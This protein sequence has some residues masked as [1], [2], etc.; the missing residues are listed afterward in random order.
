MTRKNQQTYNRINIKN[1]KIKDCSFNLLEFT[2]SGCAMQAIRL[3]KAKKRKC[4]NVFAK[5]LTL[6]MGECCTKNE[7][8]NRMYQ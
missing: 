7:C 6:N 1:N 8:T 5:K 4:P 2:L 3:G